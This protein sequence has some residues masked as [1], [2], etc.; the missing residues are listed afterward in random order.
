MPHLEKVLA[1]AE[2]ELAGDTRTIHSGQLAAR[3]PFYK[4][5]LKIEDHRLRLAHQAGGGGREICRRRVSLLDIFLRQLFV[6][7]CE[8]CLHT[9]DP[10]KTE[11]AMIAIG[12]YGRGELNPYSDVDVMFLHHF[13][14]DKTPAHV[15]EI[16]T[17]ILYVLWDI[18]FKVGHATRSIKEACDQANRDSVS[19]TALLEAR[20]LAGHGEL[21]DEF[22]AKFE[23]RCLLG[24]E[25]AYFAWR[26]E[27]QR[28]RHLKYGPTVF[29]QE[30]NVK[31]S[32]GGLRDYQNLLWTAY[33]KERVMSVKQLT[34]K[35]FIND[36]ERRTLEGAY[37][38]LLRVRTDL[39]YLASRP[40]DAL[41]LNIQ[42]QIAQRLRYPQKN[43]LRRTEAFMRDYYHHARAM[44]LVTETLFE[45]LIHDEP[46]ETPKP[47]G[48]LRLFS[49]SGPP[50]ERFDGFVAQGGMIYPETRDVFNQDP[51]VCCASSSTRRRAGCS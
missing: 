43:D 51:F 46:V 18:G 34:E 12:G 32:P 2:R 3:L 40:S 24:H 48:L 8:A 7:A 29:L 1:H 9:S 16:I 27:D 41:A 49:R 15:S 45:R 38:F 17:Q 21:L 25:K 20:Y 13:A 30:P 36:S 10:A 31:S 33:F 5:F 47:S 28:T 50:A 4:R 44:S 35:Q 14:P 37:D 42:G 11:L 23:R 26:V 19:K 22:R 6:D 39:H